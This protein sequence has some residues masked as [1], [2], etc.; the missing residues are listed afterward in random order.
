M[1]ADVVLAIMNI[2]LAGMFGAVIGSFTNVCI[3][4][5]PEH[6]TVVKG[7]SMCMTCGH[8]LGALDLVPIFSWLFLGG[9]C[10]YCKTPISSRYIKIESLTA[11]M[12]ILMAA[13]HLSMFLDPAAADPMENIFP[14]IELCALFIMINIVIVEMMIQHDTGSS[15][16]RMSLALGIDFAVQLIA[17]ILGVATNDTLSGKLCDK[18]A[19]WG[20]EILVGAMIAFAAVALAVLFAN[21]PK[22]L[23][24]YFHDSKYRAVRTSDV[25]AIVLGACIGIIPAAVAATVYL[26]GRILIGNGKS[27]KY[28][29][30]VLAGGA[31]VGYFAYCAF[32]VI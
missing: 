25:F 20:V 29:G 28:L 12:Y 32:Q 2:V 7:H 21:R 6:R 31:A 18:L 1:D 23:S 30:I 8:E 17:R 11:L 19:S 10:R 4:R 15:M 22:E 24:K 26:I 16:Y 3:Y 5:I 14:F 13:T 27:V 9:K